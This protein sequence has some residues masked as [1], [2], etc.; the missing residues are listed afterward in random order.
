MGLRLLSSLISEDFDKF[1]LHDCLKYSSP[2]Q[3][4]DAALIG[5]GH[6]TGVL[7]TEPGDL[8]FSFSDLLK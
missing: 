7:Q 5:V 8:N 3:T 6:L 2:I 1:F 4:G